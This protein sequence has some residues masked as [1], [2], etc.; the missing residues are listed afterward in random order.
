MKF[1]KHPGIQEFESSSPSYLDE[2][3]AQ[4]YQSISEG[5]P[6]NRGWIL[7][8]LFSSILYLCSYALHPNHPNG[9]NPVS[10]FY[11]NIQHESGTVG[12]PCFTSKDTADFYLSKFVL[13]SPIEKEYPSVRAV[14]SM[15][16]EKLFA[17]LKEQAKPLCV[18]VN[19][20]C[21]YS[22]SIELTDVMDRLNKQAI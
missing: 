2:L 13:S 4:E 11:F 6:I 15:L 21:A 16:G 17:Q 14:W 9:T 3:I 10:Q 12:L 19:P 20:Y 22:V 8:E 5:I 7:D 1:A 18:V